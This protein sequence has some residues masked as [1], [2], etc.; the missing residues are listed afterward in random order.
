[1][2]PRPCCSNLRIVSVTMPRMAATL[3]KVLIAVPNLGR[4]HPQTVRSLLAIQQASKQSETP[5]VR[6]LTCAPLTVARHR[7]AH[8]FL[9]HRDFT[10]LLFVDSDMGLPVDTL[11]RLLNLRT[12]I[13]CLPCPILAPG[14]PGRSRGPS[15]T[16]NLW[17]VA[18]ETDPSGA[19]L[20]RFL[21]PDDFPESPFECY[22]TGLACCLIR[23]EVFDTVPL[24][25]FAFSY[26]ADYAGLVVGEDAHFFNRCRE[27]GYPIV[28]DPGQI[29]SHFK[30]LDLS[31]FEDF[32]LDEPLE[33]TWK[34]AANTSA[35]TSFVAA[36][37]SGECH[38][39]TAAFLESQRQRNGCHVQIYSRP[40]YSE[41]LQFAVADFLKSQSQIMLLLDD[42]TVPPSDFLDRAFDSTIPFATGLF[43]EL[44][45]RGP[46][47]GCRFLGEV[48]KGP[49]LG[50]GTFQT[51]MPVE[52]ASL[53]A[54]LIARE[55]LMQVRGDWIQPGLTPV[56]AGSAL[57]YA[58]L[59]LSGIRPQ[60]L[61]IGCQHF[62][63]IDIGMLLQAKVRLKRQLRA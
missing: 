59:K 6:Y 52:S 22:G 28:A 3:A 42:R 23:R 5:T 58:V 21:D 14:L 30:E 15:V 39:A 27:A 36:I 20:V 35:P 61:P 49:A 1:M 51:P 31:H 55:L 2:K 7:L 12:A 33:W 41:A 53:R 16:S 40:S 32:F 9:A 57:A 62:D 10:H 54:T 45:A 47:W 17:K 38:G 13:A 48:A 43:R 34:S 63:T 50:P 29:C 60:L 26:R 4:V 25:W 44:T 37:C 19:L 24:P 11:D 8:E 46:E 56:S 18:P